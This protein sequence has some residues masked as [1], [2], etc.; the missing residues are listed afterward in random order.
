MYMYN[1]PLHN[2]CLR[3]SLLCTT[4]NY[5]AEKNMLAVAITCSNVLFHTLQFFAIILINQLHHVSIRAKCT[6]GIWI[7]V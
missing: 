3:F 1:T 4:P 5:K 2:T 7:L 6:I